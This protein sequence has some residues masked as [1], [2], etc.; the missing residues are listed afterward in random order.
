MIDTYSPVITLNDLVQLSE[1]LVKA[2]DAVNKVQSV[3]A[4]TVS[5]DSTLGIA[6]FDAAIA[7][8]DAATKIAKA[9]EEL[10]G[11]EVDA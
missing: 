8:C 6:R 1:S 2:A 5:D 7:I 3:G 10:A 11:R 4:H 9:I